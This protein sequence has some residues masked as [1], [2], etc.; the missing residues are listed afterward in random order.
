M[1]ST[2]ICIHFVNSK[3]NCMYENGLILFV[4]Q[5]PTQ[6]LKDISKLKHP[7]SRKTKSVAKKAKR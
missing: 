3:F 7:N 1:V 5:P 2:E 6:L 4:L